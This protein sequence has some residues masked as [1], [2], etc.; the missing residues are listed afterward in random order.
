MKTFSLINGRPTIDK[1]LGGSLYYSW[2]WSAWL[3][4]TGESILSK[5]IT[6][7]GVVL[8]SSW[9]SG[10]MVTALITGGTLET[11]ASAT[12]TITTTSVPAQ[13]EVQ[14]IYFDIVPG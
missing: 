14:T 9:I 3:A 7:D 6:V 2:D 11:P 4:I 1:S 8:V 13:V 5:V 12:C 10:S